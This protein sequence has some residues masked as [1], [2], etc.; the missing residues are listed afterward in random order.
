[1]AASSSE[2]SGRV[3]AKI[4]MEEAWENNMRDEVRNERWARWYSCSLCEQEYHGVVM[5]ALGW[6]CWKTYLGRP[7]TD[8]ARQGAICVLGGGLDAAKH[9]ADALTVR[10]AEVSMVCMRPPQ[11]GASVL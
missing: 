6:A 4:L 10:E 7:E 5:G 11:L 9:N 2:S 3:E 1:M 8:G